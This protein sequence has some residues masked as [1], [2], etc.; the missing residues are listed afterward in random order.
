MSRRHAVRLRRSSV[1]LAGERLE[2][3][4][5]LAVTPEL[6]K[7][8]NEIG[9][10]SS[11]VRLIES[12]DTLFLSF[13]NGVH[14]NE[15]WKSDGTLEGT[16]LVKDIFPGPVSSNPGAFGTFA[17]INGTLFFAANDGVHGDELWKSDGTEAGTVLVKDISPGETSYIREIVNVR[18]VAFFVADE[19]PGGQELWRSDGTEAGTFRLSDGLD[20]ARPRRLTPVG[21]TLFF[22][23]SIQVAELWKSDGTPQGT[24]AV[25]DIQPGLGDA[26]PEELVAV[27]DTLFFSALDGVTGRELWKSDGTEAGTVLVVD[28]LPGSAGS[29]PSDLVDV[30]GTLYFRA[31]DGT[32]LQLWKSDGT[33]A[34]TVL[35]PTPPSFAGPFSP[36][37]SQGRLFFVANDPVHAYELW[38]SDGTEPGTRRVKDIGFGGSSGLD[39]T[40]ELIDVDGTVYF[41][42][43]D[44]AGWGIWKSDGTY[45]GTVRV[46][47]VSGYNLT[48]VGDRVFFLVLDDKGHSLWKT[49]GTAQ[50]TV[51]LRDFSPA[52]QSASPRE[53]V[54]VNGMLFFAAEDGVYGNELWKTDGTREGTTLV[55]DIAL[56]EGW[57]QPRYLENIGGTLYFTAEQAGSGRE[58]WTSDGTEAGT[59][60]V[61]DILPGPGTSQ[62]GNLTSFRGL[63]YFSASDDPSQIQTVGQLWRTDG[64]EPGTV[65]VGGLSLQSLQSAS[66]LTVAGDTLFF[67]GRTA[68]HGRELWRSDGSPEGTALVKDIEPGIG[69][70]DIRALTAVNDTLFFTADDDR[71]DIALWKSDGTQSGTVLVRSFPASG[72]GYLRNLT[73]LNGTLFFTAN[74]LDTGIELWKSDGNSQGTVMVKDIF[75]GRDAQDRPNS[76]GGQILGT[77]GGKLLFLAT[78]GIHG[79]ELWT[80][81]GTE[82]GT[83]MV[84]D[85]RPGPSGTPFHNVAFAGDRAFFFVEESSHV[86]DLWVT[87]G[88]VRGTVR[89]AAVSEDPGGR[90]PPETMAASGGSLFFVHDDGA[91]GRELYSIPVSLP[92]DV[93]RDFTVDEADIEVLAAAIADGSTDLRFD[94]T[95]DGQ[96]T[97]ED[98]TH[99]VVGILETSFGDTNLDGRVDRADLAA[100]AA[101][102]GATDRPGWRSGDVNGDGRVNLRDL[103]TVKNNF[104]PAGGAPASLVQ[105]LLPAAIDHALPRLTATRRPRSAPPVAFAVSRRVDAV[106]DSA[107]P[108]AEDSQR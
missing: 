51:L 90:H 37:A 14:G 19:G 100:V 35:I 46:T 104:T 66:Q 9:I 96:V 95:A 24:V 108:I 33:E 72:D 84:K 81:D 27:G 98:L 7:D 70:S 68:A 31:W 80:S 42:A 39:S 69:D 67:A 3:R 17:D 85:I 2:R 48:A 71:G 65:V 94:L 44:G 77:I 75:P 52:T 43:N 20:D 79:Y 78:D 83:I 10:P 89:L 92:G 8:I 32:N 103:M 13:D 82:G 28:V 4:D 102:L 97:G 1:R 58:L 45:E 34:S 64:T 36:I 91:L 76:A 86:H 40:T 11:G 30:E 62:P 107:Q 74:L 63:A 47:D 6:V 88:T 56:G 106:L 93:T 18:G 15:L 105:R 59:K 5:L 53:L 23:T 41:Q 55:K 12:N 101:N 49:D 16:V 26:R 73:N 87:D 21:G 57:S 60:L 22:R 29:M 99:L 54:D 25:K 50:G 61:K 38:V